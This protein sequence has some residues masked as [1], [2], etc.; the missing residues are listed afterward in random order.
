MTYQWFIKYLDLKEEF[1]KSGKQLN[2]YPKHFISRYENWIKGLKWD[3]CISRQRYFGIPFPVWYCEKCKKVKLAEIKD[4]PIDPLV[5]KPKTKCSCGNNTF[6]PEKDV[7]D[8]WATS[9][10]TPQL[11]I[12]LI[13]DKS[14]QKKLFPMSLRPQAHDII[15][16]WLF[17]TLIKSQLHHKKNP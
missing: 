17:N 6:I 15:T 13:K 7:L 14:L 16:F 12:E 5:D 8:T 1:L 9:S 10:L 4:L 2:W 11:A 3:W